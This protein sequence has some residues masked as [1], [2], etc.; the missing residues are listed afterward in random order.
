MASF[1]D[2]T[3]RVWLVEFTV[4]LLE[5]IKRETGLDFDDVAGEEKSRLAF[6]EMLLGGRGRKLV[7]VL[8][9]ICRDQAEA[10][11]VTPEQ[12][13]KLFNATT[14]HASQFALMEALADFS[15]RQAMGEAMKRHLPQL[16]EK[17]DRTAVA[18]MEMELARL[19][20][21]T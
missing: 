4:G 10:A 20:A 15:P 3:G 16:F 17:M 12:F 8:W 18:A 13:G 21:S 19:T 7:E 2:K 11:N 6:T 9:V 1:Q 14:M 5:E